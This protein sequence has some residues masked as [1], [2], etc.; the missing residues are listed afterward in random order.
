MPLRQ[1]IN[2]SGLLL[3]PSVCNNTIDVAFISWHVGPSVEIIIKLFVVGSVSLFHCSVL[4][5]F[6]VE[7]PLSKSGKTSRDN[8]TL[9]AMYL[10]TAPYFS[11]Y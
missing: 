8:H 6:R 2:S 10:F 9:I 1:N 4:I 7:N 3:S 5:L 11:D